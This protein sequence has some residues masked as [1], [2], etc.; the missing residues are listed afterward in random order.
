METRSLQDPDMM[1]VV[2]LE[3]RNKAYI[4]IYNNNL[5]GPFPLRVIC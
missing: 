5:N 4:G 3:N 2:Y 1:Y